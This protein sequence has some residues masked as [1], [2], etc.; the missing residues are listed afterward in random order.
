M[1]ILTLFFI[2]FFFSFFY[3]NFSSFPHI[4]HKSNESLNSPSTDRKGVI[5]GS[6]AFA[7]HLTSLRSLWFFVWLDFLSR[8]Q[9]WRMLF[10]FSENTPQLLIIIYKYTQAQRIYRFI[11]IILSHSMVVPEI[12]SY[13][14]KI[15]YTHA[16]TYMYIHKYIIL[17][18]CMVV[19]ERFPYKKK[20]WKY[21]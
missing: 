15:I 1:I 10:L 2:L 6:T 14:Q 16:H 3:G 9:P 12:F 17:T 20:T 13:K 21:L 4:K 5:N 11:Y 7:V 18:H 8:P 19:R